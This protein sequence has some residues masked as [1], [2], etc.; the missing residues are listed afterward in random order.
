MGLYY[1]VE[2]SPVVRER[3]SGEGVGAALGSRGSVVAETAGLGDAVSSGAAPQ[4]QRK[5]TVIPTKIAAKNL[6]IINKV[7]SF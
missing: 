3:G 5:R 2:G 4:A 6:F 7:P 1:W